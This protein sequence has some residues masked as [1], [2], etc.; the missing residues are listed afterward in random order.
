MIVAGVWTGV[1]FS[2]FKNSRTRI[3]KFWNWSG[4]GVWKSDSDHLWL[5][6]LFFSTFCSLAP[7][8]F[9]TSVIWQLCYLAAVTTNPCLGRRGTAHGQQQFQVV[10]LALHQGRTKQSRRCSN[11]PF[12]PWPWTT[13]GP[14]S[15]GLSPQ[16]L[17]R[18]SFVEPYRCMADLT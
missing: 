18:Q 6:L 8:L 15:C 11:S 5:E 16:G 4:I 1:G 10:R 7:L 2:N 3:H 17:S 12:R 14:L 9:G 13:S